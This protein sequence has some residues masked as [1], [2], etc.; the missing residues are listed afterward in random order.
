MWMEIQRGEG[1]T[2]PT[3]NNEL[4]YIGDVLTLIF[5]LTDNVYWFDSNILA[6]F[7]VDGEFYVFQYIHKPLQL[8]PYIELKALSVISEGVIEKPIIFIFYWK[9]S[10]QAANRR[11]GLNGIPATTETWQQVPRCTA[12]R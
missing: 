3:L 4:V 12:E 1:P 5:T 7:A 8:I 6:C 2:A 11:P 10:L 9:S